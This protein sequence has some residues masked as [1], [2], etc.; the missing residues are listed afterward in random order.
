[1]IFFY[2]VTVY[3][4]IANEIKSRDGGDGVITPPMTC[5]GGTV[6]PNP[7]ETYCPVSEENHTALP[8]HVLYQCHLLLSN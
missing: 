8:V 6:D 4:A 2:L 1:M 5:I 3:G 7:D